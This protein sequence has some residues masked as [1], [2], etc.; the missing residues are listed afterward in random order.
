LHT[1]PPPKAALNKWLEESNTCEEEFGHLLL[2]QKAKSNG[3]IVNALRPYFESAHLDARRVFHDYIGTSLHPDADA[4]GGVPVIQYPGSLPTSAKRGLFGEVLAGLV[5]QSY[6]FVGEHEWAVPVFLF[7]NHETARDY[8]YKL[9]R[10]PDKA[11]QTFGRFGSDFIGLV[12]NEDGEVTRFIAGESKWRKLLSGSAVNDLMHGSKIDHPT[13]PGKKIHSG[14]GVWKAINDD[15]HVPSGVRQLQ[16]ILKETNPDKYAVAIVSLD[17][18]LTLKDP[19]PLPR[20]DLVIVS[21]NPG[22]TH[23]PNVCF[24]PF[25]GPPPEY[26]KGNELQLVEVHLQDGETLIDMLYDSLWNDGGGLA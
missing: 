8:L 11:S 13:K 16:R 20:T 25:E 19:D 23:E 24:L 14:E 10:H 26:K 9:A 18:A 17:Q 6:V 5:T 22:K 7:R 4:V 21:G 2:S 1:Y 3:A 15:P 12:I